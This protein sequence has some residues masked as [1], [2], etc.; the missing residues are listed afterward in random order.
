MHLFRENQ[1][2]VGLQMSVIE[3]DGSS[4]RKCKCGWGVSCDA[5]DL[6]DWTYGNEG[7][8]DVQRHML[9]KE[10]DCRDRQIDAL[11][12]RVGKLETLLGRVEKLESLYIGGYLEGTKGG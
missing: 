6:S 3:E 4:I 10:L 5:R 8:L 1:T 2:P 7:R 9:A 12:E 11:L